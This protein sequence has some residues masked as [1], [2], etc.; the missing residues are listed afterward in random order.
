M[1]NS[2]TFNLNTI[3]LGERIRHVREKAGLSQEELAHKL[4]LGQRA[5]SEIE[6]GKRRVGVT[7]LVEISVLTDVSILYLLDGE[8]DTDDLDHLLITH[9][10]KIPSTE[11][12]KAI[13]EVVRILADAI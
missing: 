7:E 10:H 13:I 8:H 2:D 3:T 9:F 5:I 6:N 12:R 11:K 4:K 1:Q